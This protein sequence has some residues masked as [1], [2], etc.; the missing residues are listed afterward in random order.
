MGFL[1]RVLCCWLSLLLATPVWVVEASLPRFG[2]A[3]GS[4]VVG[5][6][7]AATDYQPSGVTNQ[8]GYDSRNRLTSLVWKAGAN[9]LASFS[10][11]LNPLGD[12]TNLNETLAGL[13]RSY[14]WSYDTLH[15][16]QG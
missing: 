2:L 7:L 14:R 10:Y 6:N 13:N 3:R 11:G 1:R 12:R 5:G 16:L 8:Y 4:A 9:S 15:R